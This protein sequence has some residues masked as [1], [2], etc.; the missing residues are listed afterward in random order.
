MKRKVIFIGS[1]LDDLQDFPKEVR[2]EIGFALYL[3][4]T[5]GKALNA[6]PLTGFGNASVPEVIVD[7]DGDT[8][9]AVYTVRFAHAVY[10]LHAFKKKAVKGS[11]TPLKDMALVRSRL[12][13]AQEHYEQNFSK[14]V[15]K[16]DADKKE[17]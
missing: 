17:R 8:Y 7:H 3:A 14:T 4:E 5:G 16:R 15:R 12:K 2:S 10:V 1:S 6:V 9:R 11:A 13:S